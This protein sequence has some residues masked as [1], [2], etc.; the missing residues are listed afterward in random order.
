M[1][2]LVDH[3]PSSGNIHNNNYTLRSRC[4]DFITTISQI[5]S[6]IKQPCIELFLF[7]QSKFLSLVYRLWGISANPNRSF[8]SSKP[9][10]CSSDI[11]ALSQK[12][13]LSHPAE[14]ARANHLTNTAID[15]NSLDSHRHLQSDSLRQAE[16]ITFPSLIEEDFVVITENDMSSRSNIYN[17]PI[18]PSRRIVISSTLQDLFPTY[19]M[20]KFILCL[21]QGS[22]ESVRETFNAIINSVGNR[23][24]Q[25]IRSSSDNQPAMN[26]LGESPQKIF[27]TL[28]NAITCPT[29]QTFAPFWRLKQELSLHTGI[30]QR[31]FTAISYLDLMDALCFRHAFLHSFNMHKNL[32]ADYMQSIRAMPQFPTLTLGLLTNP[33]PRLSV[34]SFLYPAIIE[35]HFIQL[36]LPKTLQDFYDNDIPALTNLLESGATKVDR[37]MYCLSNPASLLYCLQDHSFCAPELLQAYVCYANY[38]VTKKTTQLNK[39]KELISEA[40]KNHSPSYELLLSFDLLVKKSLVKLYEFHGDIHDESNRLFQS[41]PIA[42]FFCTWAQTF[43]LTIE[44][45]IT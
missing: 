32:Q 15:A 9:V 42:P 19:N 37:S 5:C 23:I 18:S 45:N 10:N 3:P 40:Y 26:I 2:S 24:A 43:S 21:E 13:P 6:I 41:P 16:E 11:K 12:P 33:V 1:A 30:S 27:T 7:I 34:L 31:I 38:Q 39:A 20:E 8:V 17:T 29:R 4:N 36:A 44:N 14:S 22:P 28:L 25:E 35:Y